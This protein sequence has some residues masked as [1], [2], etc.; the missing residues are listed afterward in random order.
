[1]H[2][3]SNP[4]SI[5]TDKNYQ[6]LFTQIIKDTMLVLGPE[7][8]SAKMQKVPGL[9]ITADGTVTNTPTDPKKIVKNMVEVFMT[10]SPFLTQKMIDL[11]Y[12]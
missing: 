8:T 12:G 10:I 9:T 5:G 11:V 3:P 6:T 1:M 2:L 7:I 4:D